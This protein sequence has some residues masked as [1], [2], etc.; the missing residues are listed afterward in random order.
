MTLLYSDVYGNIPL[1]HSTNGV[2]GNVIP[3]VETLSYKG[4]AGEIL[5]QQYI[6][7][8]FSFYYATFQFNDRTI[9]SFHHEGFSLQSIVALNQDI[10]TL[11]QGMGNFLLRKE[12]FLLTHNPSNDM[13]FVFEKDKKYFAFGSSFNLT[14]V[15]EYLRVYLLA[16]E[17]SKFSSN[18]SFTLAE[19]PTLAFGKMLD[20]INNIIQ[21][22]VPSILARNYIAL[23]M[24]EL[25]MLQIAR[26]FIRKER[27]IKLSTIQM[28]A[29]EEIRSLILDDYTEHY[30]LKELSKKAHINL[31]TLKSGFKQIYGLGPYEYRKEIRMQKAKELLNQTDKPIKQI[32]AVLKF[33][34]TAS[35]AA[36]FTKHFGYPPGS[37]R[38]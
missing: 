32:A 27:K 24:E 20:V 5:I 10:E 1:K 6:T 3:G 22:P 33:A 29:L 23:K 31:H 26:I 14:F 18:I 4:N 7:G 11:L 28:E 12:H 19:R 15:D 17:M 36:A 2:G 35:F 34:G 38:K 30:T 25:F 13:S 9:T 16:E 37:D 8:N 21:T